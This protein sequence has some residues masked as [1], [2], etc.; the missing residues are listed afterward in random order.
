M[1]PS[2]TLIAFLV[3]FP[4]IAFSVMNFPKIIWM[5]WETDFEKAPL[6][7]KVSFEKTTAAAK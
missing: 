5:Y 3:L 7:T 2:F 1:K 4:C 6:I